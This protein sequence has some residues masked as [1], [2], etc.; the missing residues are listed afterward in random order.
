MNSRQKR[1]WNRLDWGLR[2]L[3]KCP[4]NGLT[5]IEL[6]QWT[7][8]YL[9]EVVFDATIEPKDRIAAGRAL[10]SSGHAEVELL[11]KQEAREEAKASGGVLP[12]LDSYPEPERLRLVEAAMVRLSAI[13]AEL[14]AKGEEARSNGILGPAMANSEDD[15]E[16][17]RSTDED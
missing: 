14:R 13:R 4:P 3:D 8:K 10:I 11:D 9:M 2:E 17:A 6:I 12:S 16:D 1:E 7:R 5:G 15:S